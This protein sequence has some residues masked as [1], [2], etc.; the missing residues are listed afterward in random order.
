MPK[1]KKLLIIR[2]SSAGDVLLT[3]PLLG[4][5][6]ENEPDSEIH[7][8]VKSQFADLIRVNPNVTRMHIVQD[9]ADFH[10]LENL[11]RELI[12]E[13]FDLTLDLHN[14]FRSIYLRRGTAERIRVIRKD[15]LR[16]IV[17]VNSRLNLYSTPRSVA[18]KY[19]RTYDPSIAHVPRPQ[20]FFP[21]PVVERM[22]LK[23]K[24]LGPETVPSLFLCPGARHFTKRWPLEYWRELSVKLQKRFRLVLLGGIADVPAC[25][26]IQRQL[27]VVNFAGEFSLIE[28]SAMLRHASAVV[29]N[30]SYLMH[31]ANALG[32]KT[33]AIFGSSVKEFG[34]F[35]YEV[36]N[37][38]LEV[39]G[40]SCRPCSH[41]GLESCPRHHFKCMKGTSPDM[42][43][44]AVVEMM[45]H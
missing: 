33:V 23:W 1:S 3:S 19:A 38:V 37:K 26:E 24:S 25:S 6:K 17:L 34:F 18:L 45:G 13:R 29:T 8:V 35:P 31:A 22:D 40:L 43:T 42:V 41:I 10:Q 16:R 20:L 30:D 14:N 7:F 44:D 39:T 15:I 27:D 21:D 32:I 2:L 12:G 28:S 5:I 11:R 9:H 36:E 4:L